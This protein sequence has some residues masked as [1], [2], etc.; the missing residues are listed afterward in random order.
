MPIPSANLRVAL[1]EEED[2]DEPGQ[3]ILD[4]RVPGLVAVLMNVSNDIGTNAPREDVAPL[5]LS[6]GALFERAIR[7]CLA[8]PA[9]IT[10]LW[11][12]EPNGL[13]VLSGTT[14][15]VSAAFMGIDT[16]PTL[17]GQRGVLLAY[18]DKSAVAA[19]RLDSLDEI[20]LMGL[21][22]AHASIQELDELPPVTTFWWRGREGWDTIRL[23]VDGDDVTAE[24]GPIL[25]KLLE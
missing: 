23:I 15:Q 21:L 10:P 3:L 18:S 22:E 12:D 19:L 5:G 24:P 13:F 17:Y 8:T 14:F 1:Y 4:R 11:E 25:I 6:D 20:D 9:E 2:F 7:N 16:I